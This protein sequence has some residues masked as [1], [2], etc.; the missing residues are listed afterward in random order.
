MLGKLQGLFPKKMYLIGGNDKEHPYNVADFTDY[1]TYTRKIFLNFIKNIDKEKIYPEKCSH[2]K[3]CRWYDE[4]EKIWKN[5]NYINQIAGIRKSQIDRFKKE[6]II[7]VEDLC[8]IN[9]DNPNLKKI[10]S[11][12]L[13]N[14]KI[15]A[16]LVQK[17]REDGKS[18]YP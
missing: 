3:I 11:K 6:N 9:L 10:N 7:T 16:E 2:C 13:S 8:K 15:K 12:T 5:D 18:D 14:L 4:C 17:K 1:F